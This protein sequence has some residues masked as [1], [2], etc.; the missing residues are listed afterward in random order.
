MRISFD[1]VAGIFDKTRGPP[2]HI[3]K[4]LVKTLTN[5]LRDY[6]TILDAGVG[7]GR[8]AKPL[9]DN[10]FEIYGIDIAKKMMSKAAEKGVNNLLRADACFIPFR[11]ESFDVTVCI[12]LLHLISEWK[13][14]LQEICRVTKEI[15]VSTFYSSKNPIREAY[16][17]LIQDSGYSTRRPGKGTNT[18]KELVKPTKSVFVSSYQTTADER[19]EYLNRRASSSQWAIPED[20]NEKAVDELRRKFTG[21]RLSQEL[22][23]LVWDKDDLQAYCSSHD[24]CMHS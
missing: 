7:T 14:A 18:L 2:K 24:A 1:R 4:K 16:N 8:F 17:R 15:M 21:K 6:K 11:N 9:Q 12:G 10:G 22:H 23:V 5:E 20:V 13:A 3:M 19:L